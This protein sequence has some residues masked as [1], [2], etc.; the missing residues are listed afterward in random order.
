MA[1]MHGE[2]LHIKVDFVENSDGCAM[3]YNAFRK[4]VILP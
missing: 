4:W 3:K 1:A 2:M